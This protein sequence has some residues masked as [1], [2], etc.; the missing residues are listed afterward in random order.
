MTIQIQQTG[1]EHEHG[2][3]ER[4][5]AI[6]EHT[7]SIP[8]LRVHNLW[9]SGVMCR[10]LSTYWPVNLPQRVVRSWGISSQCALYFD[11]PGRMD[12]GVKAFVVVVVFP[13]RTL[14]GFPA[15]CNHPLT[16]FIL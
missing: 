9:I 8:H 1:K 3:E 5:G 7:G 16:N 13:S 4:E 2:L 12:T 15:T 14:N 10:T 11:C 6:I